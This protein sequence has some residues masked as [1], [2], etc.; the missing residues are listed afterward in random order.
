MKAPASAR[1]RPPAPAKLDAPKRPTGRPTIHTPEL[2]DELCR[3]LMTG[4]SLR[5]VCLADDMPH[6]DTVLRWIH[7]DNA[8]FYGQYSRACATRAEVQRDEIL[9]IADEAPRSIV[10]EWTDHREKAK[11]VPVLVSLDQNELR[12]RELRIKAR[13]WDMAR[14]A[15]KRYGDK[16]GI[17]DADGQ[18]VGLVMFV[19]DM[20][21]RKD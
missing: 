10:L 13:Q 7:D 6:R 19:K 5:A 9:D 14:Q 17:T 1:K 20:T 15:P 2:A 12:H 4:Q 16:V 21:G 3:R 11:R 8:G 18:N